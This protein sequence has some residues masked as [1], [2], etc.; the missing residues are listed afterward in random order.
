MSDGMMRRDAR[1][2]MTA[3]LV[4]GLFVLVAS[5]C[6][7]PDWIE[8]TLVTVDVTGVWRGRMTGSAPG[9]GSG[10]M[11]MEITLQQSGPKV[12]GRY[13]FSGFTAGGG[14]VEGTVSGDMFRLHDTRGVGGLSGELQVNGDEMTGPGT[15]PRLGDVTIT[16]RRQQ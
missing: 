15:A 11:S 14:S 12:T 13:T 4:I 5:G 6:A 2:A 8:Q 16:L 1:G 3:W 7:R 10:S 9:S